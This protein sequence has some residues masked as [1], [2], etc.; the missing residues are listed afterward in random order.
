[1]PTPSVTGLNTTPLLD[2]VTI[3]FDHAPWAV[4]VQPAKEYIVH[5]AN[6]RFCD[7]LSRPPDQ[8]VGRSLKSLLPPADKCLGLL[9]R[10]FQSG[11]SA[12]FVVEASTAPF[13]LLYS[14]TLW[15]VVVD[16]MTTGVMIQ[17]NETGPLHEARQEVNQALLIGAL[18]QDELIEATEAENDR[19]KT[20]ILQRT[21]EKYIARMLT[22]ELSHRV[23]NNLSMV[24]ALIANEI[25][26]MPEPWAQGYR[27][28]QNRI[29]A[30]AYLYDLMSQGDRH[31]TVD[32]SIYLREIAKGLSE[33]ILDSLSGIRIVVEAE[34]VEISSE[35]AAT[36][37]LLVN[38]LC[39]NAVKYAFPDDIGLISLSVRG[40]GSEIELR[41]SDDGIGMQEQSKDHNSGK[42]G[43]DYVAI[44]V[45][46]LEGVLTQSTDQGRGTTFT[47]RFPAN[48][49]MISPE[50]GP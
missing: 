35:R 34:P 18:H 6:S 25:K 42:H 2:G 26:R 22:S 28:M 1:M 40:I 27:A 5:Y 36:F 21:Q 39:T 17:V 29:M 11:R 3:S 31:R 46:Q 38:E 15:P 16:G 41:I 24:S 44:F 23:K 12:I 48:P 4:V 33:S 49:M 32:L 37:G 10:V 45:N 9:D 8:V 20:E 7:L 47:I 30:I 14:Y 13:P 43:S 19:L 50:R